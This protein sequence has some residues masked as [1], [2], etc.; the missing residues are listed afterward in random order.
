LQVAH[1][2]GNAQYGSNG[3]AVVTDAWPVQALFGAVDL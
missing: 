3:D 2:R 1:G